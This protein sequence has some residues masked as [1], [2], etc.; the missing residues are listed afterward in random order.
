LFCFNQRSGVMSKPLKKNKSKRSIVC[1][2][3]CVC[4]VVFSGWGGRAVGL[5]SPTTQP[6]HPLLTPRAHTHTHIH[7]QLFFLL[8][9]PFGGLVSPTILEHFLSRTQS[10]PLRPCVCSTQSKQHPHGG[11]ST[12][13]KPIV[14]ALIFFF[15]S[16]SIPSEWKNPIDPHLCARYDG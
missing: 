1:L 8:C 10:P 13:L 11:P 3:V 6:S 12:F 7:T 14:V 16:Q 4:Y 9:F 15:S 5:L 2:C